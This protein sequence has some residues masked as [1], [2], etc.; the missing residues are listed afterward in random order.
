VERELDTSAHPHHVEE[1]A[2]GG[3]GT[4]YISSSSP[5]GR[6]R[7]GWRGYWID[8]LLLT[9]TWKRR[10]WVE[11][12]L[13]T[14]APPHHVEENALGGEGTG[15]IADMLRDNNTITGLVSVSNVYAIAR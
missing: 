10:H 1:N 2:L 9:T 5:R 8:Q 7:T 14:S 15:Y 3:E 6:E 4:G 13:D 11:R 12:E